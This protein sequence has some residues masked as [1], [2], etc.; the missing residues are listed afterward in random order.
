MLV[1]YQNLI[2]L[3]LHLNRSLF[4]FP[5]LYK[6]I[7]WCNLSHFSQISCPVRRMSLPAAAGFVYLHIYAAMAWRTVATAVMRRPAWTAASL[8]LSPADCLTPVCPETSCVTGELTAKTGGTSLHT[9]V[10]CLGHA[11][12]ILPCVRRLS[13]S[14]ETGTASVRPGGVTTP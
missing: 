12:R 2:M 5:W 9:C 6:R 8:G 10:F 3:R 1:A 7:Y 11:R 4:S 14:V 13:F